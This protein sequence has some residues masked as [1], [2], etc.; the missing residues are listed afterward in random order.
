MKLI[1]NNVGKFRDETT[2][3]LDGITVLAGDNGSGKSTIS[4]A[5]FCLFHGFYKIGQKIYRDRKREIFGLIK[6]NI[7]DRDSLRRGRG[8]SGGLIDQ[9]IDN[10]AET[11]NV[12]TIV[13]RLNEAKIQFDIDLSSEEIARKIEQALLISDHDICKRLLLRTLQEKFDGNIANVNFP[14]KEA[15]IRLLLKNRILSVSIT[16]DGTLSYLKDIDLLRDVI[17]V[18]DL[19]SGENLFG[20]NGLYSSYNWSEVGL[21]VEPNLEDVAPTITGELLKEQKAE[22]ILS[23]MTNAGIGEM[24]RKEYNSW[25]YAARNLKKPIGI[26]NISSGTKA[27]LTLKY[28]IMND[29]IDKKGVFVFD[30]PEVHLHP[31][32]QELYAE[33]IILLQKT[34]DLTILVSTH[35]TDFVSFLEYYTRKY[36]RAKYCHYYLMNDDDSGLYATAEDVTENIDKIYK[37]LGMPYIRVSEK[38]AGEEDA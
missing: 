26:E 18:D 38:L 4:K 27:F 7:I 16:P 15:S 14:E 9:I 37:E 1:I 2:I 17:Y 25:V 23:L 24:Q 21:R 30:E 31:K 6:N 8:L 19:F 36:D 32:W 35:S 34:Y 3:C 20:R 33:I 22:K 11:K 5:L 10:F 28:L 13:D 29:Q 12:Q